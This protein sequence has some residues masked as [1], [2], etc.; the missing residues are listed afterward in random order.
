MLSQA[1]HPRVG[2]TGAASYWK[3]P[4]VFKG[5]RSTEDR[6]SGCSWGSEAGFSAFS[7]LRA[8]GWGV[9]QG[10]LFPSPKGVSFTPPPLS[11]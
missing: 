4:R 6:W 2:L 10:S 1:L 7:P 8:Q 11:S 5:L 9:G 3:L